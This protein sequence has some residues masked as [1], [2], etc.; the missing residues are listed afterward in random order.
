MAGCRGVRHTRRTNGMAHGSLHVWLDRQR[1]DHAGLVT[2]SLCAP[3]LPPLPRFPPTHWLVQGDCVRA[4]IPDLA[5]H[6]VLLLDANCSSSLTRHRTWMDATLTPSALTKKGSTRCDPHSQDMSLCPS[7]IFNPASLDVLDITTLCLECSSFQQLPN[8]MPLS[9]SAR[10]RRFGRPYRT[11]GLHECGTEH[12]GGQ[13]SACE[14]HQRPCACHPPWTCRSRG[15]HRA[16]CSW[17]ILGNSDH[18]FR[19]GLLHQLLG[20]WHAVCQ[21]HAGSSLQLIF[22]LV[23]SLGDRIVVFPSIPLACVA[24]CVVSN[25]WPLHCAPPSPESARTPNLFLAPF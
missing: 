4:C 13:D 12:S 3:P 2:V 19:L 1:L 16:T 20:P 10:H 25:P 18:R 15:I 9:R 7:V 8:V 5:L 21:H 6:F 11:R 14:C 17:Y 24:L 23:P 22:F